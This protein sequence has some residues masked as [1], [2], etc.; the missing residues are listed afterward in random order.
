MNRIEIL[1]AAP[2][3]A[4]ALLAAGT[5]PQRVGVR[6]VLAAVDAESFA[7]LAALRPETAGDLWD[8]LK[9]MGV[10]AAILR[11]ESLADLAARG[12]VLNFT[13][14]EVERWRAAG[15][16]S[17]SSS[18]RGGTLWSKDAKSLVRAMEA[19]AAAGI[20]ATTTT[21]SG[22][23]GL[24]VPPGIELG[25]IPAGFDPAAVAALSSAGLIPVAA[26]TDSVA[27]LAGQRL[28]VRT[29]GVGARP[30]E[31]LRAAMS[32]PMRLIVFHPRLDAGLDANL[33]HLRG[34][35][36]TLRD[37]DQPST[38]P[39]EPPPLAEGKF[40]SGARLLLVWFLGA[41][42]PL[43][44]VRAALHV[45][46]SLR[47]KVEELAPLSSPVPQ[48]VA[49]LGAAWATAAFVALAV[50]GAA[51]IGWRDGGARGWMIWTWCAPVVVGAIAIFSAAGPKWSESWS[52]PVRR[53]DLAALAVL[54][55]A[56]T[57]LLGPRA[58]VRISAFWESF[59]QIS[60]AGAFWWWPWHWRAALV[61]VPSLALALAFVEKCD[62]VE[63]PHSIGVDPRSWLALG[64]LGPAGLV[65]VVGGGGSTLTDALAHGGWAWLIGMAVAGLLVLARNLADR[66]IS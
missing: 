21:I 57:L 4:L 45:A 58:A 18:L 39:D 12:E 20:D 52:T 1:L 61:G 34:A 16:I 2:V 24:D 47:R 50:V 27:S 3:L 29:L 44:A 38:L 15:L 55:G 13:R 53:R 11:E 51:P 63:G 22:A 10:S 54:A 6:S 8:R 56:A 7:A 35:L 60:A 43:L 5:A 30:G 9:A 42:G 17:Q 25:R 14:A 32:R 26:S 49:G 37:V 33:E 64:L 66:W 36:R 46:R 23:R 59:D 41:A 40:E 48:V 19:F 62:A 31:I 28:W 65:A